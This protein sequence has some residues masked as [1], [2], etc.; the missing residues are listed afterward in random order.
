M[1]DRVNEKISRRSFVATAAAT[2]AAFTIVPR[3][4]LGGPLHVPPSEK[5][6]IAGVGIGGK[7]Y[8]DL[9]SVES[10]NIVA[11]CDVDWGHAGRAFKRY[12][13]A[14]KWKDYRKMLDEQKDIDAVITA[15]PDHMHAL[16]SMAAIKRGLHIYTQKPLTHTVREARALAEAA[17]EHKVAS[18]MGN[19]GQAGDG[20]RRLR[21]VIWD[22]AIGPVREVHVW[23]DRPNRGFSDVYWPQGVRRPKDTPPVP[24]SLDWDLFLGPAPVRAYHPDYHPFRWRGWWD[25]GCGALGDIGCHALDPV[26]RALKLGHPLTVQAVSSLVNKETYPSASI[27]KYEFPARGDMPAV[28]VSWYDG[29]LKPHRPDELEDG[30]MM[31]TNGTL[32]V[33]DKGKIL[34]GRLIPESKQ[35]AY[36]MPGK[37]IARS[38]G[39]YEEWIN[40]CKGGE[41]AGSCFDFAGTLTE[42]VLLGNIALR[43]ELKEQVA[44][45]KLQWDPKAFKITNLPEANQFLHYEYRKGWTL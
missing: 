2:T 8:S 5:L 35:K 15:T 14:R 19:Q 41:P 31:G 6:N 30:R 45:H 27:V 32:Y 34:D 17:R 4:V 38:P 42:V 21:E 36:T 28:T 33:G 18:Q 44:R 11:L 10:Q 29:G 1:T 25:F 24:G 37:T 43:V 16:V 26:F 40:A 23:T 13:K 3:S 7:G 9:T 39:H 20:P 22:G 12:P